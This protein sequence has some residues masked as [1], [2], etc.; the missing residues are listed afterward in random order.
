MKRCVLRLSVIALFGASAAAHG[1]GREVRPASG[2][3]VGKASDE[4]R[5]AARI[6]ELETAVTQ[7]RQVQRRL[8]DSLAKST[9]QAASSVSSPLTFASTD[10]RFRV[11]LR[12]YFQSDSRFFFDDEQTPATATFLLRRVRPVWEATVGGILDLRLMPDFGEGRVT[13]FDAHADVRLSPAFNIRSGK[14]KPP[15]GMERLQSAT[16]LIFIERAI[17][18]SFAPNRDVGVQLY[19]DIRGGV[20]QYQAGVFNGV[21]DLGFGD[22]D[23][24]NNKDLFGRVLL[25]PF[26][27]SSLAAL[28]EFAIGIAASRGVHRGT[29]S[30]PF[31]QT[32]RTP[33]Q[34]AAFVFRSDGRAAGT[35]IADG[36]HTRLAPQ[37]YWYSGP[38]GT[39]WEYTRIGQVVRRD[40]ALRQ[41]DHAALNITTS[42]VLTGE[43][44]SYRGLTPAR[45]FDMQR[46][47]WGAFE[48]GLRYNTF[49]ID[50]D[51]FPVFADPNTQPRRGDSRGVALNWYL[52]RGVRFTVNY[53]VTQY[54][55]GSPL[56]NREP[57]RAIQTRI[58][59][60]F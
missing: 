43:H 28:R 17:N 38:V 13:V 41:V 21:P 19:G 3:T 6:G 53:S 32:Y 46:K 57:E 10:G 50:R 24:G 42:I 55:D 5:L 15:F 33:A 14:F 23:N 60:S 16:D 7:L 22:G 36:L 34:Q 30:A 8:A 37:G 1:Q 12:G 31:L 18:T 44:P 47:Q 4:S 9:R 29:V 58:Q 20:V 56:G 11:R 49:T 27:G 35:T 26:N 51:A 48:I 25:E 52:N 59:H 45:P 2:N 39:L 40:T 54:R